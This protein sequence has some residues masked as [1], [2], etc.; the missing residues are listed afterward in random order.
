MV[1]NIYP[2]EPGMSLAAHGLFSH[3]FSAAMIEPNPVAE[4]LK[5]QKR[6]WA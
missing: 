3:R 2:S 1:N 5:A 6:L 4:R